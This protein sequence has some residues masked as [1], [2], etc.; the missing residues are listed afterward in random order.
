M[1]IDTSHIL[2]LGPQSEISEDQDYQVKLFATLFYMHSLN[3]ITFIE[4]LC[5]LIYNA[6]NLY[7]SLC[8]KYITIFTTPTI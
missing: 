4:F 3:Y 8:F 6:V 1:W 5:K 2:V 7:V